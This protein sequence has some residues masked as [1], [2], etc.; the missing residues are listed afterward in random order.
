MS[1]VTIATFSNAFNMNV[2]KGRLETEGIP[3]FAKDEHTV[4]T[5]PFYGGALGGIK[6]QVMEQD[7]Q[8]AQ[9]ILNETGYVQPRYIPE[10]VKRQWHPLVRFLLFV[11][12]FTALLGLLY[13]VDDPI[14]TFSQPR[15]QIVLPPIL[16]KAG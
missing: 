4:T 15:P 12:F 5:N 9:R 10:P 1:L 11:V 7:V 14:G 6:L 2:L 16:P 8:E 13:L 3:A